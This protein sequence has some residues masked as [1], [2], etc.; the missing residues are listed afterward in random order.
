MRQM[1]A[2][3]RNSQSFRTTRLFVGSLC[4]LVIMA[5]V[6]LAGCGVTITTG[7]TDFGTSPGTPTATPGGAMSVKPCPGAAAT[8]AKAPNVSLTTA[9]SY[10][11]AHVHV[12]DV[13]SIALSAQMRWSNPQSAS[14]TVVTPLQPQGGM[15]GQTNTCRWLYQAVAQGTITLAFVGTPLCDPTKPCP[16]IA[17]EEEFTIQAS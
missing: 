12:G 4:L 14:Q 11:T 10:K 6:A 8:P 3:S 2:A 7:G 9:N 1:L 13:I 16:A 15:D 5:A 17:E